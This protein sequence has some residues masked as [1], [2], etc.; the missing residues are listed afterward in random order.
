[1][2]QYFFS[3]QRR[4]KNGTTPVFQE[5]ACKDAQASLSLHKA[6]SHYHAVVKYS[7]Y[8]KSFNS[9]NISSR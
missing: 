3:K 9:I 6:L 4:S 5:K 8:K 7:S 1:M 2:L